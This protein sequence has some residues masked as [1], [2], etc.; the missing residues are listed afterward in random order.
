MPLFLGPQ[1]PV[2]G[3]ALNG[4]RER[5]GRLKSLSDELGRGHAPLEFGLRV[6]T[7]VRGTVIASSPLACSAARARSRNGPA[8]STSPAIDSAY[9]LAASTASSAVRISGVLNTPAPAGEAPCRVPA[10]SSRSAARRA[11]TCTLH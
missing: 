11:G 9:W 4:V 10:G 5:I 6:T 2:L 8:R 3:R 7:L 1:A